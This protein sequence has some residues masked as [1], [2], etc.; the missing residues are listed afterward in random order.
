MYVLEIFINISKY[1]IVLDKE[2]LRNFQ[3][4]FDIL[5]GEAQSGNNNPELIKELKLYI[6]RAM[7]RNLM[8]KE[9]GIEYLLTL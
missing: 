3:K 7:K 8:K 5:L 6:F 2:E 1:P 9:E 4:N